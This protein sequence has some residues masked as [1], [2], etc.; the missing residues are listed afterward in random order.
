M[1]TG[2]YWLHNIHGIY[3]TTNG[4]L[5]STALLENSSSGDNYRALLAH[6]DKFKH[7]LWNPEAAHKTESNLVKFLNRHPGTTA[8]ETDDA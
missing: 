6:H 3:Q 8:S 2:K 1:L 7:V 5:A 4:T